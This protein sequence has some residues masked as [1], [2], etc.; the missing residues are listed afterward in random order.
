MEHNS[1]SL[2]THELYGI[3]DVLLLYR[4]EQNRIFAATGAALILSESARSDGVCRCVC[5]RVFVCRRHTITD[6][7]R[8]E[9][10]DAS[11]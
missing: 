9:E 5:W 2:Q 6:E 10:D 4:F 1:H 3:Y 7:N 8:R 11:R